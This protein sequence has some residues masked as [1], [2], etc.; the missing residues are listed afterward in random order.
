MDEPRWF[1][2]RVRVQPHHTD[3]AGV[4]WHGTY[5]TWLEEARVECL[6]S[7]ADSGSVQGSSY[8]DWIDAAIDLP[9][10]EMALKYR[11]P[12][13]LGD[14][15]LIK[16]RLLPLKGVRLRW[17]YDVQ[18]ASTGASCVQA[19]VV[20]VPLDMKQRRILRQLPEH[21]QRILE[22]LAA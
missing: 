6:R 10:V 21:L 18:N 4:V 8:K 5:V 3:Y 16:T 11:Q 2:Y 14:Q 7:Q 12:L 9:V 19:S 15:A 17:E 13:T 20:I 1:E 22:Q